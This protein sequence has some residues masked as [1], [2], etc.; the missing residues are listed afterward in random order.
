VKNLY[1][2]NYET[3][4]KEIEEEPRRSKGLPHS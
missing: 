3:L 2:E 1:N 4:K